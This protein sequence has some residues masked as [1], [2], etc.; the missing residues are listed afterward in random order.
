MIPDRAATAFDVVAHLH[1]KGE[2]EVD[3]HGRTNSQ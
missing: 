3:N 2:N 1:P